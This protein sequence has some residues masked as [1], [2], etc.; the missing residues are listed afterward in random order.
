MLASLDPGS[1]SRMGRLEGQGTGIQT[2]L[3]SSTFAKESPRIWHRAGSCWA[4]LRRITYLFIR[5]SFPEEPA[6]CQ[7]LCQESRKQ[8]W[9]RQSLPGR[10][11]GDTPYATKQQRKKRKGLSVDKPRGGRRERKGSEKSAI[12]IQTYSPSESLGSHGRGTCSVSFYSP[13]TL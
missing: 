10:V 13:T 1:R 2:L 8:G 5:P 12:H 11:H 4:T 6:V 7:A 9:T 3:P